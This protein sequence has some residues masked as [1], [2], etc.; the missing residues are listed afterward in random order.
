MTDLRTAAQLAL[1]A[2]EN[3]G[4][5]T[6]RDALQRVA[7]ITALKDALAEPVQKPA[8]RDDGMPA[9]ADERY[10]RRLLAYRVAMPG[11]Y[12]DDGEA[13]GAQHGIQIDFMREPVGH[14][15]AKLRALN[16][17]RVELQR[18]AEPVQEPHERFCDTH[19]T[20]ADHAPGCVRAEPVQENKDA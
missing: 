13:H 6:A 11:A 12:Y 15:D 7:S 5:L 8:C 17:A 10:L 19:C 1:E 9:S 3:C 2:L 20:W 4:G 18:P 16:I 14:I